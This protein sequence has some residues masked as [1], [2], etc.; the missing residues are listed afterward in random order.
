MKDPHQVILNQ[1]ISEKG[2]DCAANNNQYLFRVQPGSNKIEIKK[3]IEAI[4][5]VKVQSVQ[6]INRP[7][8]KRRRGY[9]V[10]RVP[11]Y[12]RAVVRLIEGD[13]INLT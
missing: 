12:R 11:G 2:T 6:V 4:F 13:S 9:H 10:G 5:S 3:A 8:K 1:V 7:G